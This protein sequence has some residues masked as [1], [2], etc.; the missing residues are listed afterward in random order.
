MDGGRVDAGSGIDAGPPRDGGEARDAGVDSGVPGDSGTGSVS[1]ATNFVRRT[2]MPDYRSVFSSIHQ[3]YFFRMAGRMFMWHAASNRLFGGHGG[4]TGYYSFPAGESGYP[5]HPDNDLANAYGQM[6]HVSASGTVIR[7]PSGP[8]TAHDLLFIADIDCETGEIGAFAPVEFSDG[9]DG[10]CVPSSS[11]T[12]YLCFDGTAV[13]HYASSAGSAVLELNHT[14]SLFP[15][16]PSS[17]LIFAWDGSYYYF[18][19]VPEGSISNQYLVYDDA[20][21][22]VDM[23]SAGGERFQAMYFDWSIGRY[24]T[25]DLYG[26]RTGGFTFTWV[27][28]DEIDDS[29]C[30]GPLS[31]YHTRAD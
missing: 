16:L 5:L 4:R 3:T 25:Y 10:E 18:P 1:C 26:R 14:V 15:A 23:V 6:V 12:E 29:Q 11:A 13:R 30:Y 31:T 24:V 27:D 9:F 20:G 17:P 8:P 22:F 19:E 21:E 7:T 28:G 2:S